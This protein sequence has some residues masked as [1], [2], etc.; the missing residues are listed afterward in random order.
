MGEAS[1]GV[2]GGVVAE[3]VGA[4]A[5]EWDMSMRSGLRC[6]RGV[7]VR[8]PELNRTKPPRNTRANRGG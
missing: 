7:G 5:S 8:K 6:F 2:F 3:G 4:G 1:G